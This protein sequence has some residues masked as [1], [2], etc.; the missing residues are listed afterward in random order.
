MSG[1]ITSCSLSE[2][3][4]LTPN[5]APIARA[6][7]A[8]WALSARIS[9][10]G[11]ARSAGMWAVL[12]QPRMGLTPMIPTPNVDVDI[13]TADVVSCVLCPG[14]LKAKDLVD[15]HHGDPPRGDL[16]IDDDHLVDRAV[17]AVRSLSAGV[18]EPQRIFIDPSQ[19]LLEV[20]HDLLRPDDENDPSGAADIRPKLAAA[21]RSRKQRPG[22]G[23]CVDAPEHDVRRRAKAADLVGLGL[24]V[25]APDPRSE[26]V[27]AP[28]LVDLVGNAHNVERLRGP[29][30]HLG[31]IRDEV[32]DNPFCRRGV[33]RTEDGD[34]IRLEGGDRPLYAR[35]IRCRPV[36]AAE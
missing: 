20:R 21:H 4:S 24:A 5:A 6:D 9:Y 2:N 10:F 18:F 32:K 19:T 14:Y 30:G 36:L 7:S 17:D 25:H 27:V 1:W 15:Q 3:T 28:G 22:L 35:L 31:A 12:A 13:A 16:P 11:S 8:S 23:D 26:R 34:S 33:G 29:M